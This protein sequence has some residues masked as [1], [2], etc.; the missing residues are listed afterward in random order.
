M[1]VLPAKSMPP[2]ASNGLKKT[3]MC[4]VNAGQR[5][6]HANEILIYFGALLNHVAVGASKGAA[7]EVGNAARRKKADV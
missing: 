7:T 6:H 2:P 4:T 1:L 5:P 3:N